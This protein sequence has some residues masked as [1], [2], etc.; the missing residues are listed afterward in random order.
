M[1]TGSVPIQRLRDVLP[2]VFPGAG[3]VKCLLGAQSIEREECI[4][5]VE[6]RPYVAANELLPHCDWTLCHGGQNTI[7]QSLCYGVP[8]LTFPGPI[9]ERRFNAQKVQ[10]AGAGLMGEVTDFTVRWLA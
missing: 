4:G 7:M 8:L 6:F 9:F 1:G 2:Q 5:G 3:D 10:Q